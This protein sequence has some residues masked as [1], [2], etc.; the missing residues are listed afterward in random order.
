MRS[1]SFAAV[2][3]A[4]ERVTPIRAKYI[5][6]R[7]DSEIE[8]QLNI[9]LATSEQNRITAKPDSKMGL[10]V[11]GQ[12]GA[13]KSTMLK[14]LLG[15]HPAL[16]RDGDPNHL[17]LVSIR[18]ESPLTF[19]SLGLQ[20]LRALG[21]QQVRDNSKA[22]YWADVRDQLELRRVKVLHF[23]EAQEVFLASSATD[24]RG[25][26]DMFKGLMGNERWPTVVV[27]S[28]VPILERLMEQNYQTLRR[29]YRAPLLPISQSGGEPAVEVQIRGYAALAGLT[30][31]M[32]S[33]LAARLI[34]A[35]DDQLGL[36][37]EIIVD[38]VQEA[39]MAESA[40]LDVSHFADAYQRHTA[41]DLD[42]NIF[43]S[44]Q[45]KELRSLRV[46]D[47]PIPEVPTPKRGRKPRELGPW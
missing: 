8:T 44:A 45:W 16:A 5:E 12:S 9:L 21:Y 3:A 38:A 41:C 11:T 24:A 47:Q 22:N 36:T 31:D 26:L 4:A 2:S 20:T 17:P 18:M 42:L 13:G 25:I 30:L 32:Q 39:F 46:A 15:R 37:M 19:K 7:R 23:D 35:A 34:Q 1:F 43:L 40:T 14:R 33:D 29:Y 10:L 28:G 6:T 27:L